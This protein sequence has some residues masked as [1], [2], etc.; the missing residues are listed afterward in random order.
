MYRRQQVEIDIFKSSAEGRAG[1][2]NAE[3]NHANFSF[4]LIRVSIEWMEGN[5]TT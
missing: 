4:Y 3:Q 5:I 1:C 2:V